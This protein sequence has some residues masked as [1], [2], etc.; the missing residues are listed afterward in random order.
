VRIL[1]IDI[2]SLR[3]DHLGC[4]G[5]HRSTSPNIDRIAE[6]GVRF[7]NCYYS[8]GPCQPSRTA[9]FSGR[10]GIH[11][12][13]VD[14]IGTAAEHFVE[15]P[16]R[17][18]RST[19]GIT[20]WMACLKDL[21]YRTATISSFAER[22]SIY[23]WLAGFGEIHNVDKKGLEMAEDMST[24]A[25]DWFA[26]H[27]QSD[28]WFLHVNFWDVHW[29]YRTP[30]SFG[31]PF[32]NTP[33]PDWL[34]EEV[35]QSHWNGCGIQSAQ[36]MFDFHIRFPDFLR[37]PSRA[38]SMDDVRLMFD[39]YDTGIRYVDQTIGYLQERLESLGVWE[40]TAIIIAADH[41]ENLGELNIY[42]GHR[43]ADH[44]SAR[45]PVII[46]WPGVTDNQSGRVDKSFH[47]HMD[48][49]ATVLDLVGRSV[50]ENW[51]GVSFAKSFRAGEEEGRE[52][53]V[54]GAGAG[55]LTR[56]IRFGDYL[57]LRIY[58]DGYQCL[59]DTMLFN[60]A[61]D[62][63]QQHDLA[64]KHPELV[65]KAMELF[66]R[67]YMKMMRT[68]THPQDNMW[69]SLSEGGPQDT[70]GTL[71]SYLKRLQE[72]GRTEWAKKLA[73]KF[74]RELNHHDAGVVVKHG[75]MEPDCKAIQK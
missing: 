9:L 25:C 61:R 34:T 71:S 39:G 66:N 5:Y 68:A 7:D 11:T 70:R 45:L 48:Y 20:N 10:F 58:H 49:A 62:P 73:A 52:F 31:N 75:Y 26:K 12:G 44:P 69:V 2:D 19:L 67:W 29:P 8:D 38:A 51:D 35:R 13:V 6:Q 53:L 64:P 46:R 55:G 40:D 60:V 27:A 23:P 37:T 18:F 74:P 21:G 42:S 56:S 24:I 36:D 32:A 57:C 63:H 65:G 3:A 72:T 1:Y 47:Y 14:H 54:I 33:I 41:G 59:P 4:Y 22:H 16:S 15:G 50:P 30:E 43:L 17:G 28:N